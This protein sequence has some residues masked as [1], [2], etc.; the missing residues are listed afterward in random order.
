MYACICCISVS[1]VRQ[2]ALARPKDSRCA[3]GEPHLEHPSGRGQYNAFDRPSTQLMN[4]SRQFMGAYQEI[5]ALVENSSFPQF[6]TIQSMV[7]NYPRRVVCAWRVTR[8]VQWNSTLTSI[9]HTH[10]VHPLRPRH[11]DW[12]DNWILYLGVTRSPASVPSRIS[13]LWSYVLRGRLHAGVFRI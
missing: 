6:L 10:R 4:R 5:Y 13:R 7:I 9:I 12:L 2:G 1:R 8:S 3:V 11:N